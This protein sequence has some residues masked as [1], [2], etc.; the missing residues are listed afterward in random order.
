MMIRR[1]EHRPTWHG[2]T[3]TRSPASYRGR[4][5]SIE[6]HSTCGLWR[7]R[8][9]T[10]TGVS[11]SPLVLPSQ[12]RSDNQSSTDDPIQSYILTAPLNNTHKH[13]TPFDTNIFQSSISPLSLS[14]SLRS[15]LIIL[16]IVLF[17]P[18][19]LGPAPTGFRNVSRHILTVLTTLHDTH[20][21]CS[22]SLCNLL[23]S[24]LASSPVRPSEHLNAIYVIPSAYII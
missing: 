1:T 7:W 12:Y 20:N 23:H 21:P 3:N 9:G 24:S 13:I 5:Y 4:T 19:I 10:R 18:S 22:S 14:T 6:G 11:L 2:Q 17:N 15:I 8:C 16:L